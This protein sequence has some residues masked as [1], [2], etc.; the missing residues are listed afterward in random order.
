MIY[1]RF[2][3][4]GWEENFR[5]MS[6][7]YLNKAMSLYPN[8]SDVYCAFGYIYLQEKDTETARKYVN[9]STLYG[10]FINRLLKKTKYSL[11]LLFR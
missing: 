2:N 10:I 8:N 11:L 3:P 9:N 1:Q 7:D 5:P 6:K 4:E